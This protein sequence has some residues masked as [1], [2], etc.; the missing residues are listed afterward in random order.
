MDSWATASGNVINS[1]SRLFDGWQDDLRRDTAR[2]AKVTEKLQELSSRS[3]KARQ[4][5]GDLILLWL[6]RVMIW[7]VI[8]V[9][10]L[11][12]VGMILAVWSLSGSFRNN[13]IPFRPRVLPSRNIKQTISAVSGISPEPRND[14]ASISAISAVCQKPETEFYKEFM[15]ADRGARPEQQGKA[16]KRQRKGHSSGSRLRI[17]SQGTRPIGYQATRA[18]RGR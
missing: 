7:V 12:Q 6:N 2:L 9:A 16:C 3:V 10:V 15:E 11:F 5:S 17:A 13:D 14:D 8:A 18:G 4:F 1:C